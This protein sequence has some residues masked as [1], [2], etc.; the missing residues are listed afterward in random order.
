MGVA[1]RY[2][3]LRGPKRVVKIVS[4]NAV[5]RVDQSGRRNIVI[6]DDQ[7]FKRLFDI[8]EHTELDAWDN[9]CSYYMVERICPKC[10]KMNAIRVTHRPGYPDGGS[11]LWYCDNCS[12]P[13][14]K[15]D[16]VRGRVSV[17]G[18]NI[19]TVAVSI[20]D[21]LA[22][23][24]AIVKEDERIENEARVA[25]VPYERFSFIPP[26][27]EPEPDTTIDDLPF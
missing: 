5:I 14:A 9:L 7:Q 1:Q 8:T 16:A 4:S 22:T 20:A 25:S 15:L 11:G 2:A 12:R 24:E 27:G 3:I 19:G 18:R 6:A 13:L 17:R 21:A 26:V 23:M 10:G